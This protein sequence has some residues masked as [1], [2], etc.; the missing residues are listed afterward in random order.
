MCTIYSSNNT[1]L[2]LA[3]KRRLKPNQEE[4]NL[5]IVEQLL[6]HGANTNLRDGVTNL[7][8]V[9]LVKFWERG[10]ELVS[11]L[12]EDNQQLGRSGR[13]ISNIP[14]IPN[15]PAVKLQVQSPGT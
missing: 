9:E 15:S 10:E 14:D 13:R 8:P 4:E 1:A 12:N 6:E 2:H 7:L 3:L 11:L 5:Q